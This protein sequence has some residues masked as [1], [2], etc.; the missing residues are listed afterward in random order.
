MRR[1]ETFELNKKFLPEL[2][3]LA[4]IVHSSVINLSGL[5]AECDETG[6][7]FV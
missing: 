7:G 5:V 6:S 4:N 1:D 2:R 3:T